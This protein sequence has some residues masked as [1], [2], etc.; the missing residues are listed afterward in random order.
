MNSSQIIRANSIATGETRS[1]RP[2][3]PIFGSG[4]KVVSWIIYRLAFIPLQTDPWILGCGFTAMLSM[5]E[6]AATSIS[7]AVA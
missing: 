6:T 2:K 3:T 5:A 7:S 4:D 1:G